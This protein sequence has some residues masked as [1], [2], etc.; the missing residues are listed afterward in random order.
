MLDT[1]LNKYIF[2]KEGTNPPVWLD[3]SGSAV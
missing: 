1:T 3:T 2:Y